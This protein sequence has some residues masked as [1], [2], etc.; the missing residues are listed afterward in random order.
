V[1]IGVARPLALDVVSLPTESASA[2][3]PATALSR[4][5]TTLRSGATACLAGIALV[6]AIGL[7]SAFAQSGRLAVLSLAATALCL[8][9]AF[10]LAAAPASASRQ[11]WRAVAA[12]A[13]LVLAGWAAP[14]AVTLP[15]L[16][17]ARGHWATMPGAA[18]AAAAAVCLVL[19]A[20]AAER[21]ARATARGL[22]VALAAV[23]AL[24]PGAGALLFALG[25]GPPGGEAAIAD[26][27]HV[28][29]HSTAAEPDIQLRPG[30]NGN[31]YVTPVSTPPHPPAFAVALAVAAAFVFVYGAVGYLRR[32]SAPSRPVG[33]RRRATAGRRQRRRGGLTGVS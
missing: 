30:R 27:V 16:A 12:T 1:S 9:S 11:L 26:D 4:R 6:Q 18:C 5:E 13:G 21:P 33:D 29:A 2:R 7:P 15:D 32:C 23:V 22:A 20:A 24:G 31:H 14:H 25:P 3:E 8:G 28:H 17:G 10:G 19:A